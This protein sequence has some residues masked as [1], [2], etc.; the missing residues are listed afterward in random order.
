M[1]M[2]SV[3]MNNLSF[4]LFIKEGMGRVSLLFEIVGT[5]VL[6]PIIFVVFLLDEDRMMLDFG[7]FFFYDNLFFFVKMM[8]VLRHLN[9]LRTV[10]GFDLLRHVDPVMYTENLN[11][12]KPGSCMPKSDCLC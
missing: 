2:Y 7:R 11:N 5:L 1:F 4:P 10:N 12:I 8:M 6:R 9:N 3:R